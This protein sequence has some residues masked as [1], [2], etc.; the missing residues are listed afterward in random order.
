MIY[1]GHLACSRL[2]DNGEKAKEE[3]EREAR[4]GKKR[5][6]FLHKSHPRSPQFSRVLFSRSLS[7][8]SFSPISESLEQATGHPTS[9]LMGPFDGTNRKTLWARHVP[10]PRKHVRNS[11]GD[12]F[13]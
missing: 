4:T 5:E 11:K 1:S 10:E 6:G 9:K 13:S 2:Q 12:I 3:S 8:F 7:Y